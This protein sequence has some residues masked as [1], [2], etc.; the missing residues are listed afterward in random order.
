MSRDLKRS[1]VHSRR[2]ILGA[3]VGGAAAIAAGTL[4]R[5]TSAD[6]ASSALMTEVDN[7]TAL[8]TSISAGSSITSDGDVGFGV[9]VGDLATALHGDTASG[10]GIHGTAVNG[11]GVTGDATGGTG[12]IGRIGDPSTYGGG[13]AGVSGFSSVPGAPGINGDGDIGVQAG[14][15]IGVFAVGAPSIVG[16]GDGLGPPGQFGTGVYGFSGA[17]NPPQPPDNVG[18]YARGDGAS[19]ALKVQGK[20]TFSRSGRSYVSASHSSRLVTLAGVTTTSLVIVTLQ[21]YRSGVYVAAAVPASGKFTVYL[22]KAVTATTYF[23]YF[24]LN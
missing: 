10:I 24:I 12:V 17:V 19:V 22:S 15:L 13:K 23:A 6:A 4:V 7:P 16:V 2:S 14:G 21:T 8:T 5:P 18:V 11:A 3:A 9:R 20:A 1:E